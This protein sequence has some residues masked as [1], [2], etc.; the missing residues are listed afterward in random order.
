[1][2]P[3]KAELADVIATITKEAL[4]YLEGLDD[5]MVVGP[6]ADEALAS[7]DTRCPESGEGSMEVLHQLL[8]EG[9][10]AAT[11]SSGP[12]FFHFVI[13]GVTP[14]ALG[15]DWLA[16][17]LDQNPG[18]WL[19]SP[20]GTRL[21]TISL[22][23]L[24]EMFGLPA[25]WGGVLTTGAQMANYTAL[26][27]ARHWWAEQHGIDIETNGFGGLPPAP[28]FSSGYVHASA[29]KAIG[30]LGLGQ[31]N[32]QMVTAD[33]SGRLDL[34]SLERKLQELDGAPAILIGNAGEVNTGAFDP[35]ADMADLAEKYDAWLHIDGAFGLF[36][37]LSPRTDHL[38]TGIDRAHSVIA[39]GHKWM[40]VP[41][42]CGFS[43]VRDPDLLLKSFRMTAAA[44]LVRGGDDKPDLAFMSPESSRR[45]RS[46]PLWATLRAYGRE[47]YRTMVE[48]HLDLAQRVA[49]RVDDADDLERMADV[50]LNIV[51]FRYHPA[52]APEG[53]LDE[54][55]AR[56]GKA[57]LDDGRVYVGTTTYRG[58]VCFRPAIV[59]WRTREADVDLMVDVI[60]ELGARVKS[61]R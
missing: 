30:M 38:V 7:F 31:A 36:A 51:C 10:D 18:L 24:K 28:V 37:A 15:A 49:Q 54:L 61:S 22:S 2:D 40:N 43:F 42:D 14:A 20:L 11:H 6:R 1:M 19:G 56:L 16:S 41:Y 32:L 52:D 57:V 34:E 53:S 13:G 55:N 23:W 25:A 60:R 33:D 8:A 48:G 3:N 44:Y 27:C 47:G 29:V 12:R 59:N 46:L 35:I 26:A 39:D 50:P 4:T 5:R 21:E 58:K 9:I 17:L 45:A